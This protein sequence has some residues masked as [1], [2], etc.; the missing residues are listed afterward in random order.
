MRPSPSSAPIFPYPSR[1]T[2]SAHSHNPPRPE[3]LRSRPSLPSPLFPLRSLPPTL[4]AQ[5]QERL[6]L[7][8]KASSHRALTFQSH[9]AFRTEKG[10]RK[11]NKT[12]LSVWVEDERT[13]WGDI[14]RILRRSSVGE[15]KREETA[16]ADFRF[17]SR[18]SSLGEG[19]G[20]LS[21]PYEPHLPGGYCPLEGCRRGQE[22]WRHGWIER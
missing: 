12:S 17:S 1:P 9:S 21:G 11:S 4:P 7:S 19:A 14:E 5:R 16:V 10:S 13:E 8:S 2:I 22:R 15:R 18:E 6:R 3:S 20:R